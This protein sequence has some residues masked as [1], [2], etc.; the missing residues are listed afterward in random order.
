[1]ALTIGADERTPYPSLIQALSQYYSLNDSDGLTEIDS[2]QSLSAPE[3]PG[4][5]ADFPFHAAGI[6][7]AAAGGAFFFKDFFEH[8]V[9]E[10]R[11]VLRGE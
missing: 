8:L 3:A 4:V 11:F 2:G 7:T 9:V 10:R 6:V 5:I 1:M